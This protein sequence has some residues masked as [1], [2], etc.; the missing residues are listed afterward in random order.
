MEH[1]QSLHMESVSNARELGGYL[2]QDGRYV[3]RG[4]LLR[5][6]ALS[7]ASEKDLERLVSEYHVA[8]IAD[9]RSLEEMKTKKDPEI[10]GAVHYALPIFD[11]QEMQGQEEAVLTDRMYIYFLSAKK[12]IQSFR[13]FLEI[14]AG[15]PEG[16]SLLFHC[17][18]GKDRTGL[19]AMLLLSV[20]GAD[21]ETIL[22]DYL[23]TNQFNEKLI[24]QARSMLQ[25]IYPPEKVEQYMSFM[26]RADPVF[27]QNVLD[28]MKEAYGSVCG[29]VLDCLGLPD[30]VQEKI[31]ERYLEI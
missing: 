14:A 11:A 7:E 27:M 31:R 22:S 20:L 12:G 9:F 5:T 24:E 23:L 26:D 10:A 3:K 8:A 28:W 21:E 13:K 18:Q 2:V 30:S 29:Y 1:P 15:L 17:T 6:G 4:V 16:K 19:A 25:A